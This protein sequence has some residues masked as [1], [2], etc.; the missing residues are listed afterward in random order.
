[1]RAA[2]LRRLGRAELVVALGDARLVVAAARQARVEVLRRALGARVALR[3]EEGGAPV[4]GAG[5][6]RAV[7]VVR[8][9]DAAEVRARG[10]LRVLRLAVVVRL[11]ALQAVVGQ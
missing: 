7:A 6:G 1:M 3:L 8:A 10:A 2:L 9:L 4:V 11:A 5:A